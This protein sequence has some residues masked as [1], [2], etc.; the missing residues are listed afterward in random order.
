MSLDKIQQMVSSLAAS[1]AD[2]ERIAT[3]ILTA[4]LAKAVEAYP[5][6][7]T[8][9][10]MLRVIG[11][12]AENK[13]FFIRRGELK[14][15]YTKLFSRNTKFAEVFAQ[16]LGAMPTTL[17][18]A[19]KTIEH[20]EAVQIN[21]YQ[22]G[23][24]IL[25]N[26]LN[27]VF[28]HTLPVKMYSQTL[29]DQ[30]QRSVA[31]TLDAWNLRPT[32]LTVG[33][34]ND[35]FLVVRA[36]YE[37]PKGVVSVYVP[38]EIHHNKITE[39]SLFMGNTGPQELNHTNLK[40]YLTSHTNAK[41]VI[42]AA[43]ILSVLTKAATENRDLSDAELALTRLNATRQGKADFCQN[44]VVG[45]KIDVAP[46]PEV[47]MPR[48]SQLDSFEKKLATPQ[49]QADYLFGHSLVNT[50]R[51]FIVRQ[52]TSYGH[53]NPQVAVSKI[54]NETLFYSIALEAGRVGF[55]VPVKISQGKIAQP[56]LMLCN[57]SIAPFD[58]QGVNELCLNKY[59]DVKAAAAASPSYEL[60]SKDLLHTLRQALTEG[61]LAGA[62]DTL[63]VLSSR[64]DQQAYATGFQMY[65]N[66]LS[67]KKEAVNQVTCSMILKNSTSQYP[68]CGHTGLPTHKV[69][70]DKDG[71]CRPLFRQGMND[72]YEGAIFNNS[73]IFG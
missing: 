29:A 55:V 47:E 45:Q 16:E 35:K 19:P 6:D 72:T 57:G 28:D 27:S 42:D 44:Q 64:Q 9:G 4:K 69:Y 37:T 63:N 33:D 59:S 17:S 46:R 56:T 23:D 1:V 66:G 5:S 20:D 11:K 2:N 24:Q 58:Q 62:E 38:V 73:K 51:D 48:S 50:A 31:S 53:K 30:A 68:I 12:M 70:Q 54:E 36:D 13:T 14:Q 52:L 18:M 49:G 39:A 22:V 34:G 65:I 67:F 43:T 21:P 40:G 8:L 3:P 32:K 15:L 61:N 41:L 10:S 25:A 7:Q 71:N 60:S 26:A